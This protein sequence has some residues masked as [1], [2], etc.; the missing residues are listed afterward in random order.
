M[1]DVLD[2]LE[3]SPE[4]RVLLAQCTPEERA[5][6]LSLSADLDTALVGASA[7]GEAGALPEEPELLDSVLGTLVLGKGSR[8]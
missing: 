4:E 2:R 7:S 8:A 3:L 6:L 5:Q 1:A